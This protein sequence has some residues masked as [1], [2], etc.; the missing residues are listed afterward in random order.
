[1]RTLFAT[2]LGKNNHN[3]NAIPTVYSRSDDYVPRVALGFWQI[4]YNILYCSGLR[5]IFYTHM[6]STNARSWNC[7]YLFPERKYVQLHEY[8]IYLWTWLSWRTSSTCKNDGQRRGGILSHTITSQLSIIYAFS[9]S[10]CLDPE[11][12]HCEWRGD[13]LPGFLHGWAP[14]KIPGG[15]GVGRIQ[16]QRRVL[17][18]FPSTYI[19][20]ILFQHF[21]D[22]VSNSFRLLGLAHVLQP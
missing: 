21:W 1:M 10:Q 14:L 12:S 11:V 16:L 6:Q 22:Q 20:Y 5:R 7:N 2:D 3:S 15:G 13:I 4:I 9:L 19:L 17:T 18:L 8:I